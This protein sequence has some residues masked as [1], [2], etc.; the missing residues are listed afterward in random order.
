MVAARGFS[1]RP[2]RRNRLSHKLRKSWP[3]ASPG[4]SRAN[5]RRSSSRGTS[6][7]S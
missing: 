5:T 7:C 3:C 1:L 4:S 2:R 6:I